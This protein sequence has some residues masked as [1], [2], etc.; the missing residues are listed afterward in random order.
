MP[1]Y[2]FECNDCKNKFD[3]ILDFKDS[4][5]KPICTK[6]KSK[7]TKRIIATAKIIIK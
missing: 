3:K 4:Q 1:V 2:N 6:C 7:N 5:S